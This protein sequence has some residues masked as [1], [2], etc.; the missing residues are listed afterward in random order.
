[1]VTSEKGE[2]VCI[3]LVGKSPIGIIKNSCDVLS[4]K[5]NISMNQTFYSDGIKILNSYDDSTST[6]RIALCVTSNV[7]VA[8]ST[9]KQL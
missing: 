3:S 6:P 9:F 8:S 2:G 1:M 7:W 5:C 4:Q